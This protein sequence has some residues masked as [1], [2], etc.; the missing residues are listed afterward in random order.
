MELAAE[1]LGFY[2][3][4][5]EAARLFHGLGRLEFARM[6]ELLPRYFPTAPAAAADIGGGPGAYACWLAAAGHQVH[7]DPLRLHVARTCW[8]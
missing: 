6:Q 2:N 8:A 5:K 1:V 4:G 7:L 3:E